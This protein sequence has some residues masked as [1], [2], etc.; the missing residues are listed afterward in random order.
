M[1]KMNGAVLRFFPT[2]KKKL[3]FNNFKRIKK[4]NNFLQEHAISDP[5]ANLLAHYKQQPLYHPQH[6]LKKTNLY[7]RKTHHFNFIKRN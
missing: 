2:I 6:L 7:S 4:L 1:T 3:I 5:L